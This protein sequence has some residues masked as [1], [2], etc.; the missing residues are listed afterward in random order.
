MNK[1]EQVEALKVALDLEAT[2][3]DN[4]AKLNKLLKEEYK[5]APK[6]PQKP[7]HKT[8]KAAVYPKP[9]SNIKFVDQLKTIPIIIWILA[10]CFTG[11]IVTIILLIIKY[12]DYKQLK[13]NDVER[14]KNSDEYK[15]KCKAIDREVLDIQEKYDEEYKQKLEEYNKA[16]SDYESIIIPQY[17]QALKAWND[18]HTKEIASIETTLNEARSDLATH[19]AETKVIPVQYRKLDIIKYLYDMTSTSD[20]DIKEAIDKYD[21]KLQREL[22]MDRLRE[23][24]VSN[25]QQRI[26]NEIAEAQ[27]SLLDEQNYLAHE[28]NEIAEKAR[29]NANTAAAISIAQR[30]KTNKILDKKL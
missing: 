26:A 15:E 19:Y 22:D 2:I 9:E 7:E 20:Y 5:A 27:A 25:E 4:Q 8:A 11:G 28:Q 1:N 17:N 10:T 29:R 12:K 3:V 23:Q 6:A 16:L 14:I 18:N 24:R 30:H 21:Q 13:A